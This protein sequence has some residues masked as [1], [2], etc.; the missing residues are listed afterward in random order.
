MENSLEKN[1]D[2]RNEVAS[3]VNSYQVRRKLP[4]RERSMR[5]NFEPTPQ[6]PAVMKSAFLQSRP[7]HIPAALRNIPL[8]PAPFELESVLEQ[9][10]V[11]VEETSPVAVLAVEV[12]EYAVLEEVLEENEADGRPVTLQEAEDYPSAPEDN[13][14]HFPRPAVYPAYYEELAE[15]VLDRPRILDV[16]EGLQLN[17]TPLSDIGL[18]ACEDADARQRLEIEVPLQVASFGSRALAAVVDLVVTMAAAAVF[19]MVVLQWPVQLP[20]TRLGAALAPAVV[21]ILWAAYQYI[22]LV[23]AGT[24]LGMQALGLRLKSFE[25]GPV[26]RNRRRWRAL[27]ILCSSLPLGLGLAWAFFDEDSLCWHDRISHSYVTRLS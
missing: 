16:P 15:P 22:F 17:L 25:S 19:A 6:E 8:E 10:P 14:L 9:L 5:L 24:T 1:F 23:Y 20:A 12:P 7:A 3:R 2:W 27:G 26:N 18:G 4:P 11:A 13:I 21:C